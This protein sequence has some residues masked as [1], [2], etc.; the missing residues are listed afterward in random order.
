[1]GVKVGDFVSVIS[2]GNC[3]ANY[4]EF[5]NKYAPKWKENRHIDCGKVIAIA[6]HF[7]PNMR[8]RV[9][10]VVEYHGVQ[11]IYGVQG[12]RIGLS[13]EADEEWG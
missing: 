9:L 3:Y 11:V 13:S 6:N 10:A 1:M 4:T 2:Q 12:L 5:A 8:D 7:A